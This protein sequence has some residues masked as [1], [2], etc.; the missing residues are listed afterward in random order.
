[1]EYSN[2]QKAMV[3]FFIGIMLA[4]G[5]QAGLSLTDHVVMSIITALAAGLIARFVSR[6]FI[7]ALNH[8]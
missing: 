5:F 8:R 3:G 7:R 4:I 1:M 6:V 2:S